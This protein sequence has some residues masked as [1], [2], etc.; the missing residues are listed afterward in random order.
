M[1][2]KSAPVFERNGSGSITAP[3]KEAYEQLLALTDWIGSAYVNAYQKITTG[4]GEAQDRLAT[5]DQSD[6][7]K[8]VPSLVASAA[9]PDGLRNAAEG[10]REAGDVLVEMGTQIGMAYVDAYEQ[11]V[12]AAAECREALAARSGSQL[13][14][15]VA[16]ARAELMREIA[17]TCA[18]TAREIMA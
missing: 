15:T 17:G 6:W 4:I 12:G 9:G 11:A 18:S 3:T 16:S 2:Q 1:S 7:L 10:A 5:T 14:K 8:E 13:V